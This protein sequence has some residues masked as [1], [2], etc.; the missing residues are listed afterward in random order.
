[1]AIINCPECGKEGVSDK[2]VSCPSCAYGIKEHFEGQIPKCPSCSSTKI[3]KITT[4]SRLISVGLVGFASS[5]IGKQYM[6]ESC[7]HKW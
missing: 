5:K 1:M 2:A 6:C 7:K 4:T 3:K